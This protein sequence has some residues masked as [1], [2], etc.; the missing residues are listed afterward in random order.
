M[1]GKDSLSYS[2]IPQMIIFKSLKNAKTQR[3]EY[4]AAMCRLEVTT[5][6]MWVSFFLPFYY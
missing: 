2:L 3:Q 4:R 5:V 1:L 6:D